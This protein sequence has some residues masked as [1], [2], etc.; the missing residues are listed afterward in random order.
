MTHS[1][2]LIKKVHQDSKEAILRSANEAKQFAGRVQE[3]YATRKQA[4]QVA[5]LPT[6]I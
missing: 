4:L 1:K 2:E 6:R 5:P 3:F